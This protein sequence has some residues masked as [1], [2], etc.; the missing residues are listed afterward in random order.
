[1]STTVCNRELK[2]SWKQRNEFPHSNNNVLRKKTLDFLAR[3]FYNP[4]NNTLT[5]TMMEMSNA[6]VLKRTDGR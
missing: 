6:Q 1:M 2:L 3:T 4:D 5:N